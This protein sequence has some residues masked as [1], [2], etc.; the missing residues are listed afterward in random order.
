MTRLINSQ[1]SGS[2]LRR[3]GQ[4]LAR[5]A[6][7]S[8]V[9]GAGG[10]K[11]GAEVATGPSCE[12]RQAA[13]LDVLKKLPHESL[14][15]PVQVTLA[16]STLRGAFGKGS[17][18]QLSDRSIILDGQSI[19]GGNTAEQLET[20]GAR[21]KQLQTEQS[22]VAGAPGAKSSAKESD[23]AAPLRLYIA[24]ARDLDVT[25]LHGYLKAVPRQFELRLLFAVPPVSIAAEP[26]EHELPAKVLA[27]R[28]M[29][30]RHALARQGYADY[31]ECKAVADAAASVEGLNDHERWP[32]LQDA[33]LR[34]IPQCECDD[35]DADGLRLLLAAEQRA[36]T[37]ALAS[38]PMDFLRDQRCTAAMP[39]RS[40]Q[41]ILDDVDEFDAEFSGDWKNDELHFDDVVTD[42]RLLNTLCGAMP[43]DT[44]ASLQR[45][46]ATLYWRVPGQATC[47]AWRIESLS[48]GAPLG[49]WTKQTDG[50]QSLAFHF[51]QAGEEIRLFG[52]TTEKSRA[53][54]DGPWPC[55]QELHMV[56]QDEHSIWLEHGGRWYFDQ[57]ACESAPAS[58]AVIGGCISSIAGGGPVPALP[59]APAAPASSE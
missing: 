51:R 24:A 42:D 8:A 30:T 55:D 43:G 44:L 45:E 56:D 34:A 38:I 29:K 23:K 54:D 27:E 18:L 9:A 50:G 10:C 6:L 17:I 2:E 25:T 41:Q 26:D 49:T 48:R 7:V 13:L 19:E 39:L 57:A 5:I 4:V 33:M 46:S 37:V 52:P 1:K 14:A 3:V 31:S 21:L 40:V 11:G 15:A 16:A 20:L 22:S 36:G 35:L 12:Q 47:Q 32:R 28:D 59:P 53:T 58:S